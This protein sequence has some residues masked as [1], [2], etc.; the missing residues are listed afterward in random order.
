MR[1][2]FI[3]IISLS[4]AFITICAPLIPKFHMFSSI[5][6]KSTKQK[7]C[8]F[9]YYLFPN[10]SFDWVCFLHL[11]GVELVRNKVGGRGVRFSRQIWTFLTSETLVFCI[12]VGSLH[13]KY[14]V[15][16]K[17]WMIFFG[18]LLFAPTIF[19][20]PSPLKP[21]FLHAP[22]KSYPPPPKKKWKK[23]ND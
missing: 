9:L 6:T 13:K 10:E 23:Y 20:L 19:L 21:H 18:D 11:G 7:P 8:I 12:L 17:S 5:D 15:T 16:A 2:F 3:S 14:A 4:H 1:W 22:L